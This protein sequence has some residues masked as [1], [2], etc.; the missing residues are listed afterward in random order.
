MPR[1]FT[2]RGFTI[3]ELQKMSMDQFINLIPSRYR[4][5]L[6]RVSQ[7]QKKFLEKI[8]KIKSSGK[9]GVKIRTHFRE[10]VILPEMVG[11]TIYVHNGKEFLPVEITP[12]HIGH[13]LGEF[14]PTCKKVVH[15]NPG[16]GATKSSLY[17]PLK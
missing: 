16:I 14:A 5:S 4:R 8:R 13:Y 17:V 10:A 6:K 7:Q 3:E 9:S 2:Y 1:E 12:E 11:L 15:G